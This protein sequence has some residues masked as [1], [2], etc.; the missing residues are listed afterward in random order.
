VGGG[1]PSAQRCLPVV[2]VCGG[3]VEYP[4]TSSCTTTTTTR[5]SSQLHAWVA[6]TGSNPDPCSGRARSLLRSDFVNATLH[7]LHYWVY[8]L[9]LVPYCFTYCTGSEKSVGKVRGQV[10][11]VAK[12]CPVLPL[13]V[14][15]QFVTQ[16]RYCQPGSVGIAQAQRW[17][18]GASFVEV[19]QGTATVT[20]KASLDNTAA[21]VKKHSR[22]PTLLCWGGR[23]A[24]SLV[25][26]RP[27]H[28]VCGLL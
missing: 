2:V 24:K 16:R 3:A 21:N 8:F 23:R 22:K 20:S 5:T 6:L 25:H 9:D 28:Q 12:W 15:G 19:L 1:V 10:G 13:S 14:S 18:I 7:T 27:R 26:A 4:P 11:D 17:W